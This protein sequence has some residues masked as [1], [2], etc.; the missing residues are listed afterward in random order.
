MKSRII[1]L[2]LCSALFVAPACGQ[3]KNR[4]VTF[5]AY[6]WD[7]GNINV[8]D[9]TVCHTFKMKNNTKQDIKIG[10][11]IASCECIAAHYSD[12]ALK[13]RS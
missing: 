7:F 9:G 8:E 1:S 4:A 11:T 10:K 2:L 3:V 6:E 5:D 12:D 13:Q